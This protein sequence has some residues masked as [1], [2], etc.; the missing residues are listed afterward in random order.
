MNEHSYKNK[1]G[2]AAWRFL[3]LMAQGY[4]RRPS[5]KQKL[6]MKLFLDTFAEIYPCSLCSDHMKLMFQRNPY[7]LDSREEFMIY[8]CQIHN[9]VNKR[10]GKDEFKCNI[11]NL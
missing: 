1:L 8:L 6:Y 9:I 2:N 11:D 10:L 7:K 3:H 5:K 4:P